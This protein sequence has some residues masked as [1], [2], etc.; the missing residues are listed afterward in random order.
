M[1]QLKYI[2][3]E[4]TLK[5]RILAHGFMPTGKLPS[6][7][8]LC[9]LQNLS[10]ATVL[11]AL[12]RLESQG[13]IYVKPKSGYFVTQTKPVKRA[14]PK[15]IATPLTPQNVSVPTILKDIMTRSAAFDILPSAGIPS[16]AA[17]LTILNRHITKA[18]RTSSDQKAFYYNNSDGNLALKYALL[19]HYHTLKQKPDELCITNG[20]QHSLFISLM[21]TCSPGDTVAVE[22]PT[23]YGVLQILEQLDLKILEIECDPEHGLSIVDLTKKI[24]QWP[25]KACV[26]SPNYS[27]PTGAYMPQNAREALLKLAIQRNFCIIEDD[28]YGDLSFP[29][30]YSE[31]LKSLD[32][33]GEVILCSSFSKSLSRDLRIGWVFGGKWHEK[34]TQL[35]LV[36]QLSSCESIQQGLAS[37][38]EGGHYRRY[39]NKH[40]YAIKQQQQQLINFLQSHWPEEIRFTQAHGGISMWVELDES[41]DTQ[42]SYNEILQ[43]GIVMTP[44]SLFSASG[45][46]KNFLRLSYIHPFTKK[47]EVAIKKLF[48]TLFAKKTQNV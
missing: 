31:P 45:Q 22:S 41:I 3:L 48:C 18:F 19:S 36:T 15:Q 5:K 29:P 10:K 7:R 12:H 39:L 16:D 24:T 28:I 6:V 23:F 25:I 4:A 44:G 17:H 34:I 42:K 21:A 43:Q 20:C 13:F 47:R 40:V 27:T 8:E 46:Y 32:T 37:F 1:K 2:E 30:F 11:H 14:I 38:I 9:K 26:V 33:R 35:K